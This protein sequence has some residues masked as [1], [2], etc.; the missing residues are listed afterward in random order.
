MS[1]KKRVYDDDDGRTIV[2]MS[3]VSTP[4]MFIPR[5]EPKPKENRVYQEDKPRRPWEDSGYSR[6]ERTMIILGTMKAALLIA[7]VYLA[8]LALVIALIC[9]AA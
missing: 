4:N 3:G 6:K 8:G 1:R 5:R 2:D 7:L 9:W